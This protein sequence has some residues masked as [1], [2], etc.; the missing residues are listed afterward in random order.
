MLINSQYFHS[1]TVQVHVTLSDNTTVHPTQS[2]WCSPLKRKPTA[3]WWFMMPTSNIQKRTS[4]HYFTRKTMDFMRE[5]RI[6]KC[7]VYSLNN[8]T[9]EALTW[10]VRIFWDVKMSLGE[11]FLTSWRNF[12]PIFSRPSNLRRIV[13]VLF[14]LDGLTLKKLRPNTHP[15]CWKPFIQWQC[16]NQRLEFY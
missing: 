9:F 11:W 7:I 3:S 14:L 2:V 1:T 12:V 5:S 8:E 4:R 13:N 6:C 10:R 15:K 16:H